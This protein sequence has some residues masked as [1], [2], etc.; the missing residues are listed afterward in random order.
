MKEI[1]IL[2][3]LPAIAAGQVKSKEFKVTVKL[4]SIK[5]GEKLYLEYI[6][7]SD[8]VDP[9]RTDSI[10]FIDDKIVFKGRISEPV[11]A[12]IYRYKVRIIDTAYY[13]RI[14]KDLPLPNDEKEELLPYLLNPLQ[15][16][17]IEFFLLFGE[18]TIKA[19]E[20][21][22]SGKTEGAKPVSDFEKL[23]RDD[24][25][26]MKKHFSLMDGF[27]GLAAMTK[28]D[29]A[30]EEKS[31]KKMDSLNKRKQDEVYLAFVRT[32]P[33]S[34]LALYALKQGLPHKV[35]SAGKYIALFS[36]LPAEVQQWPSAKKMIEFLTA[37]RNTETGRM[38]PD[39]RQFDSLGRT[40]SF[41]SFKGKYVLLEFWASWCG[42][43]RKKNPGLISIYN[44]YSKEKFTILGIALEQKDDREKWLNAIQKDKL[45]WPQ[46]TDYKFWDN[47][48]ARQFGIRS[49]PFNL[50]IDPTGKILGS[51][52]YGEELDKRLAEIFGK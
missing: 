7:T 35:D 42:P 38:V 17:A 37:A 14:L 3:L 39:F 24:A 9:V 25:Q 29:T 52:L 20:N 28:K 48:V 30:Y 41:S 47:A 32:N 1:L 33:G 2:L 51:D 36:T 21:L 23:K 31:M 49:I 4:D 5:V 50:L 12:K 45:T 13:L 10:A 15:M 34:P 16:E 26:Y 6:N 19:R 40:V 22:K 11:P 46:V 27:L 18:T 44:K 8:Q 43:C